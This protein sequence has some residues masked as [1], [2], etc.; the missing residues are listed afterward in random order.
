MHLLLLFVTLAPDPSA[1][2]RQQVPLAPRPSYDRCIETSNGGD[3]PMMECVAA[4]AEYQD[5]RLN[6]LYKQWMARLAPAQ[7]VKLRDSERQWLRTRSSKCA[8][9]EKAASPESAGTME[10]LLY[11]TC[12]LNVLIARVDFLERYRP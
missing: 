12:A 8:A 7:R 9:E 5:G 10:M 6:A 11:K 1:L 3:G 2:T 4:E